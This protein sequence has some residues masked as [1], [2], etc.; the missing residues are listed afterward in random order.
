[1]RRSYDVLTRPVAA[2][3]NG[4][5]SLSPTEGVV[6][7]DGKPASGRKRKPRAADDDGG[8]DSDGSSVS[9]P[10]ARVDARTLARSDAAPHAYALA[11]RAASAP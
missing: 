8:D 6:S 10:L 2:W 9:G 3:L 5:L 4:C 1:M 7:P 11:R